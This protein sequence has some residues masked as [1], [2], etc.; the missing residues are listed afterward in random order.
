MSAF[1]RRVVVSPLVASLSLLIAACAAPADQASTP[2]DAASVDSEL[3]LSQRAAV[4]TLSNE[5]QNAVIA[6]KRGLDGSLTLAGKTFTGAWGRAA[7]WAR[8]ARWR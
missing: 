5:A 8:R 1:S 2:D 4:F 7:G 6:F 3:S